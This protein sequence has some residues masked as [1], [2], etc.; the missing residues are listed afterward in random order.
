MSVDSC[1][2]AHGEG[3]AANCLGTTWLNSERGF[4]TITT[5]VPKVGAADSS[6]TL[7][8][9]LLGQIPGANPFTIPFGVTCARGHDHVSDAI[10]PIAMVLIA[11]AP[12]DQV[13][14]EI[15]GGKFVGSQCDLLLGEGQEK[16]CS[17]QVAEGLWAPCDTASP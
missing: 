14:G 11:D 7:K 4:S 9:K 10:E 5:H 13:V 8:L 3:D 2:L 12:G 17:I 1:S 15:K 16:S 6:I